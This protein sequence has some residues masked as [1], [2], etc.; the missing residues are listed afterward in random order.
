M[1]LRERRVT[2]HEK[3]GHTMRST[4]RYLAFAI[5]GLVVVQAGAIAWA[6]F[7]LTNEIDSCE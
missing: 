2:H 4:Y 7:G 1:L 3:W 5:A 6:F